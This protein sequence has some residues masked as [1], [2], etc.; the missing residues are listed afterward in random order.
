MGFT[1]EAVPWRET[2]SQIRELM[3]QASPGV[4]TESAP[5][6]GSVLVSW[7]GRGRILPASEPEPA[8]WHSSG[9]SRAPVAT[10]SGYQPATYRFGGEGGRPD[11]LIPK[12]FF[13][14]ALLHWLR[15]TARPV[16]RWVVMGTS[17]SAW[18]AVLEGTVDPAQASRDPDVESQSRH[19]RQASEAG[20]VTQADLD[21]WEQRLLPYMDGL[22]LRLRLVGAGD[23]EESQQAIWKVLWESIPHRASVILDITHGFRHQPV[24]S[25]FML[26]LLQ[27]LR[28]FQ[29][30]DLY[31]GA[32]E[33]AE[34]GQACPVLHL[35]LCNTLLEASE[36]VATFHYT[37]NAGPLFS[38]K[39]LGLSSDKALRL[40]QDVRADGERVT[41]ADAVNQP[42]PATS[43][44]G[45]VKKA[46][47]LIDNPIARPLADLA[48]QA[49]DWAA[50]PN[51]PRRLLRKARFASQHSDYMKAIILLYE[52]LVQAG[53]A[54]QHRGKALDRDVRERAWNQLLGKVGALE[55]PTLEAV[56]MLRN[57]VAH[58]SPPAGDAP[59]VARVQAALSSPA[60]FRRIFD[61][62]AALLEKVIGAGGDPPPT[63]PS[64]QGAAPFGPGG[65]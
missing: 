28:R 24:I 39:A 62:G 43:P 41:Y 8:S 22:D 52:G 18:A 44:A 50:E 60:E 42:Q 31:Y 11:T 13:G 27:W 36:A 23:T 5:V 64:S 51:L 47:G 17:H 26:S 49:V 30:L 25:A 40:D 20:A 32:F 15:G 58:A 65:A 54:P 34:R 9:T 38:C 12:S 45:R 61:E 16:G 48:T 63:H 37:G 33:L 10:H 35:G 4:E 55:V 19:L 6:H 56:R 21:R 53:L 14:A 7:V 57:C 59:A 2:L 46:L 3:A 29:Q 1:G